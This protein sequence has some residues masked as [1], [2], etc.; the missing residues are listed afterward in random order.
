MCWCWCQGRTPVILAQQ[1]AR[2]FVCFYLEVWIEASAQLQGET[3]LSTVIPN[4]CT[5]SNK[6]WFAFLTVGHVCMSL[7]ARLQ[8]HTVVLLGDAFV[9]G[10]RASS[11]CV[12]KTSV[13]IKRFHLLIFEMVWVM[14]GG[15]HFISTNTG[16]HWTLRC[17]FLLCATCHEARKTNVR[18]VFSSLQLSVWENKHFVRPTKPFFSLQWRPPKKTKRTRIRTSRSTQTCCHVKAL[19]CT[20]NPLTLVSFLVPEWAKCWEM[21]VVRPVDLAEVSCYEI[22]TTAEKWRL[23]SNPCTSE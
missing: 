12:Y 23:S 4:V 9:D 11:N 15:V 8:Q 13:A 22:N 19:D 17:V 21:F 20:L 5:L 14:Q 7:G 3:F 18:F 2:R 1:G 16:F 10:L 6:R